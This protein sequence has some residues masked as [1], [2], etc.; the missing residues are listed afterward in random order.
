MERDQGQG[1]PEER[2]GQQEGHLSPMVMLMVMLYSVKQRLRNRVVPF[3]ALR[4]AIQ[5]N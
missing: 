1:H 4:T 2:Q 3:V 5:I